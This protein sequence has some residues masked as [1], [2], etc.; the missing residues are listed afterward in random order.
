MNLLA[1]QAESLFWLGRYL[2]RTSSLARI[3]M[4]QTAFD[5]G[6]ANGSSWAWLL[7][8]YDEREDFL[9]RYDTTD[10][11]HVIRY[12]VNDIE[13][14]G[15]ILRSLEAARFNA[16]NLRAMVSTEFWTQV[17]RSYR[18]VKDLPEQAMRETRLAATCESIQID[19]Y[20]VFGIADATLYRDAGW[21][22]TNSVERSNRP[23]R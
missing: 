11:R 6:R 20:A 17:N 4:V 15:S 8:L 16:R 14:G 1:R 2:E 12:F 9:S 22:F 18:K 5:R 3:L 23:T 13:H 19:C 21:R 10:A 7:A